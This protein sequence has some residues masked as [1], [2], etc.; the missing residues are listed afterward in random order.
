M[1]RLLGRRRGIR[2]AGSLPQVLSSLGLVDQHAHGIL[3]E[4]PAT[5]DAFRGLFSESGQPEQ[6]PHVATSATYRRAI[7]ELASFLGC[8]PTESA[9]Y[10]RRLATPADEYASSL[11]RATGTEWLL[12]DDG[13]P[14]PDEG[15]GWQ[16]M[17]ELAGCASAPVLRIERV[18]EEAL[19][20]GERRLDEL[21]ERVRDAVTR[22]RAG[23]WAALKTIAAYRSGLDVGPP[24]DAAAAEAL[25]RGGRRL[26]AKPLVDAVLHA[27]LEANERAGPL[28]VQVHCGFGDEDLLLPAARPGL[29]GSLLERYRATPFVLLH[30]YPFVREAGWLAHVYANVCFDLSLTIPHVA[31]PAEAL[32]EALELAPFS[33]LMYASDAARTPELYFLAA[34]W[35]RE[36]LAE[37]LP[38]LLATAEVEEAARAILRENALRLYGLA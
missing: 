6:W 29:L 18:A 37:V 25:A 26:E 1:E 21:L 11:L 7:R 5:L 31:R 34:R 12:L 10:E 14:A 24:D 23:G 19:A 27:A 4:P 2:A 3:R 30:C 28:P 36:A 22:A 15:E 9:V 35:W 16:R 8:E 32:R 38:E 33:K 17:G 20:A 13:F